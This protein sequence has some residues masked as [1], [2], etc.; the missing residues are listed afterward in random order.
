MWAVFENKRER[1]VEDSQEIP[2]PGTQKAQQN[3]PLIGSQ[4]LQVLKKC[5]ET[6]PAMSKVWGWGWG[7][8]EWLGEGVGVMH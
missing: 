7:S 2:W 4:E 5:R 3:K 8:W 6:V 1:S